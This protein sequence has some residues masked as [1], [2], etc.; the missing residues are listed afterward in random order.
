MVIIVVETFGED[1]LRKLSLKGTRKEVQKQ[2]KQNK[3][4]ILLNLLLQF[5]MLNLPQGV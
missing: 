2:S 5:F 1:T 4:K 3:V